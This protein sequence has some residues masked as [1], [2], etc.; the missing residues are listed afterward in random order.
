VLILFGFQEAQSAAKQWAAPQTI[1]PLALGVVLVF[2]A[3]VYE[4]YTKKEPILPPRLFQT[5]T[6]GVVLVATFLHAM[7][8]F[9]ASYYVPLYFQILGSSATMS[10]VRQMPMS[11][12]SSITA[13]ISGIIVSKTGKYRPVMWF[14]WVGMTLGYGLMIML[15]E[16]SST[17]KQELVLLVAGVGAGCFFQP[18][19]IALQAA[20]PLKDMAVSTA[21]YTLMRTLGATVGISVGDTIFASEVTKR[22]AKIS[23]YNS[24]VSGNEVTA[25]FSALSKIQPLALRQQ[26]LHAFTRSLATIWIVNVPIAFV[27]LLLVLLVRQY[28][29]KQ[30]VVRNPKIEKDKPAG[31]K[32]EDDADAENAS[33]SEKKEAN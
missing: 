10:G 29:L 13:I 15:E 27:G 1:A 17:A 8:F 26:V 4:L 22:L 11:V 19:L 28:T 6:T 2:V 9:G 21:A 14:A 25:D 12:G 32:T 16:N 7:T 33:N 23:G 31:A 20:M 5:R 18:P 30:Q 3:A 24:G